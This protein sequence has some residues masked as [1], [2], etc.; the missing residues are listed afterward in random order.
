MVT[1]KTFLTI[2]ACGLG[3][4][5]ALAQNAPPR[6][7]PAPTNPPAPSVQAP[8]DPGYE[9][10]IKTCKTPPPAGRGRGGG[11]GQGRSVVGRH[12]TMANLACYPAVN[13]VPGFNATGYPLSMTF[14]ARPFGDGELLA[15]ARAYQDAAGH[16][17]K[18][19]TL[20]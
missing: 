20:A 6:L 13:V 17:L 4:T 18:H 1:S 5:I 12:F 9:A 19:P 2:A 8:A 14:F 16:H 7:P 10:L 15:V 11:G 3:S